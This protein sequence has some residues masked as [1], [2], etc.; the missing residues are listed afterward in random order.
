MNLFDFLLLICI[1][2][3]FRT[4]ANKPRISRRNIFFLPYNRLA[5]EKT[6]FYSCMYVQ[7][8]TEK[9][10]SRRHLELGFLYHLIRGKERKK[11]A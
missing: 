11:R 2:S 10:D 4:L 8:F 9:C 1:L 6:D 3:V 5:R 7:E